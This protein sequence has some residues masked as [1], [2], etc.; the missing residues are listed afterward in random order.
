L[1]SFRTLT[2]LMRMSSLPGL[3]VDL[4]RTFALIAEEGSFTRAAERVGR[5]QSAVSLQVQRVE[6]IVGH[7]LFVRGRGGAVQVT[8]QGRNL[9]SRASEM[10][11][12][13]DQ[14]VSSLRAQPKH[15]EVRIGLP[16]D[17]LQLNIAEM[18]VRFSE[19]HPGISAEV[20]GA[21]SCSLMP[22]LKSGD[23]D[24]LVCEAGIEPRKWP[25]IEL[26]R[27]KLH[28]ITSDRHSPHLEDPL[29]VCL[30]PG[31][32]PWRP[33][34]LEECQWRGAALKALERAGRQY[35]IVSTSTYLA[36][37]MKTV[38]AGLAVTVCTLPGLAEGLRACRPD[39]GL[40]DLP[41]VSTLLLKAREP[42]QPVTDLLAAHI[43]E[44]LQAR[45][46]GGRSKAGAARRAK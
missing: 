25:S 2:I 5:T 18:I 27:G 42:R 36:D 34:W 15:T 4:L 32:C 43:I 24:L 1:H 11:A 22:L 12:L 10:L 38:R 19:A 17:Y 30:S 13:N 9:L 45:Q 33:A 8:P 3:D 26:W 20:V 41:E 28:W 40:P 6:G 31:N 14:I 21:P 44:A 46:S 23:L 16:E 39:E 29:P 37:M 35:R 7:R